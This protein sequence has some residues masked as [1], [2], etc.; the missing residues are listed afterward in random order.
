MVSGVPPG[1]FWSWACASRCCVRRARRWKPWPH[2]AH[3][4]AGSEE[5][6]CR[7]LFRCELWRKRWPH[8]WQVCGRSSVCVR[9]CSLRIELRPKAFPQHRHKKD[10]AP[11]CER[12]W[13]ASRRANCGKLMPQSVQ[14][15]LNSGSDLGA[16]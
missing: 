14:M 10:R 3:R 16:S 5:C 2:S 8:R 12:S 11:G 6:V 9:M 13:C 1:G 7:C 4:K 15:N